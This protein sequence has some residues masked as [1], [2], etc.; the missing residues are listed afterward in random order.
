MTDAEHYCGD[1]GMVAS[2]RPREI[3]IDIVSDVVCP[4]CVVGYLQLREAL[5]ALADR[6]VARVRWHPF[7]LN[8]RMPQAGQALREHM[9]QKYGASEAQSRAARERLTAAGDALGFHFDYF[10]GMRMVNTFRA[11]Q[12]LHWA[13]IQGLQSE[14]QMT[15]FEAF[16][17]RR[18]DVNDSAVLVDAA[19]RTGLD[20]AVAAALLADGRY[21]DAVREAEEV[22]RDREV[23]AVPTFVFQQQYSVPGAQ[24]AETFARVMDRLLERAD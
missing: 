16:F 15:L 21:A 13:A 4:W 10:D 23:Y 7:E 11:H 9:A 19:R 12:L 14:L 6:V 22:W 18:Q 17:S 2:A 1:G 24:E 20:A 8:P 3:T 5:T